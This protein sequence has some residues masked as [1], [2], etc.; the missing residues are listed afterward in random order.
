MSASRK[1]HVR[2]FAILREQA[3]LSALDVVTGAVTP[4]TLYAELQARYALTFPLRLLRVAVNERY[5][6]LT[7]PLAGGDR[8]VFI[9][10]VAGG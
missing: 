5:A 4:G 8:V 3:G 7:T 6:D 2:L 9:P 1:I 10:P